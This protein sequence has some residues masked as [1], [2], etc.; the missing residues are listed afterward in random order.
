M[1]QTK[2]IATQA[3]WGMAG[4][5]F[6]SLTNF[7][8][9]VAVARS[10]PPEQFGAF[11]IAL[12]TYWLALNVSRALATQPLLIRYSGSAAA[13]WRSAL[14][15]ASG[16]VSVAGVIGG[17]ACI[18]VG[19]I[20]GNT[21]G[22]AF[23]ALGL[24]LPGL[25]LRDNL[26]YAFFA[27]RRARSAIVND[28][29]F[30]ALL[31]VG[32]GLCVLLGNASVFRLVLSLSVAASAAAVFG[33]VQS[34]VWPRPLR[35][36]TWWRDQA[37]LGSRY[38]A[39]ALTGLGAGQLATYGIGMV[40]GLAAVG[41][42]RAAEIVLGPVNIVLQGLGLMSLPEGVRLLRTSPRRLRDACALL[43][44]ALCAGALLCG[45]AALLLP[46]EIGRALLGA[47]WEPARGVLV[48]MAFVL[49]GTG[50][51]SGAQTGLRALAAAN[52]SLQ[53][54]LV[55]AVLSPI[56][57][58]TGAGLGGASLAAWGLAVVGAVSAVMWW[59]QFAIALREHE[60][61]LVAATVY[62]AAA[63]QPHGYGRI[64]G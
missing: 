13:V 43:S 60:P 8:L 39:E 3:G 29:A 9:G 4:Q 49:A 24:G 18:V 40:A 58:I 2:R 7:A 10:V 11:S 48:P 23:V 17:V 56:A 47:N 64:D 34:G 12:V 21:L 59:W 41:A 36:A 28:L 55:S 32:I 53:A 54:R 16:A 1:T 37:D 33:S 44:L 61:E 50:V 46:P 31:F 62:T 51:V 5:T 45:A 6:S 26:R 25:L 35:A 52:R 20:A 30:A 42:I 38:I 22:E 57:A 63:P 15:D 27:E 14:A 19:W